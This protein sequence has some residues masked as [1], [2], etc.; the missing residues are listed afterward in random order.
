MESAQRLSRVEIARCLFA[1]AAATAIW[2]GVFQLSTGWTLALGIGLII[3]TLIWRQGE[4][5]A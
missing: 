5:S 2:S 4:A 3:V 1:A